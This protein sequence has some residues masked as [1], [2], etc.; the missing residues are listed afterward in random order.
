LRAVP[1][2]HDLISDPDVALEGGAYTS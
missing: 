1:I 2:P